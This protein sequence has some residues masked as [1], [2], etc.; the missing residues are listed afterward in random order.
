MSRKDRF[1]YDD[2]KGLG[3][4]VKRSREQ[5]NKTKETFAEM[6]NRSMN[7]VSELEKGNVGCSVH[8]LHQISKTLKVPVDRL[9]YGE[10]NDMAKDD[11]S[12][13]E[14]LEEIINRCDEDEIKVITDMVVA[15]YPNLKKVLE[16]NNKLDAKK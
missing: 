4:R 2:W 15:L 5:I 9:L 14:I 10:S 13:K 11:Y 3:A 7:T 12:N 8:T 6:I 16:K 1:E